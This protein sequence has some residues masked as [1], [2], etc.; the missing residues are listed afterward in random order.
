MRLEVHYLTKDQRLEL[1]NVQN[2][3][4]PGATAEDD[5]A[6]QLTRFFEDFPETAPPTNN[7]LL[8]SAATTYCLLS[9]FSQGILMLKAK[10]KSKS[11][12]HRY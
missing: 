1:S 4:I 5:L 2:F 6:R 7:P 12:F 8:P 11:H 10:K 3:A 9:Q